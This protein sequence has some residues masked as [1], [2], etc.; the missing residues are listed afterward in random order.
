[1]QEN[2]KKLNFV[3][4]GTPDVSSKTLEVLK[5][6]GYMPSLIVT[7][8]D[9]PVGRHFVMTPPPTKTWALENNIPFIQPERI[10]P[11]I[12]ESLPDAD[13]YVVVAYGKILPQ[14]LIDKPKLATLNIHY[15]LL[16]KYRG[17]SP[18]ESAILNGDTETG[19]SIQK[20]Y[21][22]LMQGLLSQNLALQLILTIQHTPCEIN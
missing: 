6:H 12:I 3:Y 17:A 5:T 9:R 1:M 4:F 8:P 20:W 13:V 2:S 7:A 21:L 11:D 10:T 22:N 14:I 15:S 16:P 19:V 18:V